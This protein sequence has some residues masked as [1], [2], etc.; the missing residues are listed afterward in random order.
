MELKEYFDSYYEL[1]V[2]NKEYI[3]ENDWTKIE[4]KEKR[5]IDYH[6]TTLAKEEE[7]K[8]HDSLVDFTV[9]RLAKLISNYK[10]SKREREYIKFLD[11][12]K[13]IIDIH[14]KRSIEYIKTFKYSEI[15]KASDRLTEVK[16]Q[17]KVSNET[18]KIVDKISGLNMS[19][20]DEEEVIEFHDGK[21]APLIMH[22][23]L[24]NLYPGIKKILDDKGIDF[25][26]PPKNTLHI[27]N[28]N[29]PEWNPRL[30]Y[31]DQDKETLQYY[32]DEWKKM[33]LGIEIDGV[34]IS[35]WMYYHMNFFVTKYPDQ[36]LN[37]LTGQYESID[38]IGTPPVRD[39]EW[40]VIMDNYE[41]AKKEGL[42]M[43]LA[44]TRRAAKTTMEASHLGH[45]VIDEKLEL[46]V[47]G[48]SSTDL[49]VLEKNFNICQ[50][51][52]HPAFRVYF[53]L[54]DSGKRIELGIK[55][56][57]SKTVLQ[58][59]LAIRNMDGGVK[60]KSEIFAGLTPDAVV[61]D[62][63]MK[64]PFKSQ[65]EGLKPAIDQPGGKRCVV[66]LAGC[67]CKGTKV[68]DAKGKVHNI[69]DI[70]LG[71]TILG[72][73]GVGASVENVSWVK[74]PAKKPCYRITFT[75]GTTLEC[76]NDHPILISE[77][78]NKNS[79]R[80]EKA[81]N[82][83]VGQKAYVINEIAPFGDTKE[84]DAYLLGVLI[85]DGYNG[86]RGSEIYTEGEGVF[87]ELSS[88]YNLKVMEEYTTSSGR[89]YRRSFIRDSKEITEK[90]GIIGL[91]SLYKKLPHNWSEYD[92]E[93]LSELI[94]GL[95]DSD[96]SV[97]FK[98]GHCRIRYNSICERIVK[99]LKLALMK[100]GIHSTIS[101]SNR[102]VSNIK[103]KDY[104]IKRQ[105]ELSISKAED[106]KLF[107]NNIK[108]REDYKQ[109]TQ[110]QLDNLKIKNSQ[111]KL[112]FITKTYKDKG[113][114]FEG[115]SDFSGIR[116]VT[117]KSVEF[118]GEQDVYNITA[119]TTHTYIANGII[120]HNTAGNEDLAKD[121][122]EF[123]SD[124][125][126]NGVLNMP[127]EKFNRM[128]P[129]EH[130]TWAERPFGTFIPA[131][132][133]AKDG[134]VKLDSNLAEFLGVNSKKL[135]RIPIKITDWGKAKEKIKQDRD[136]LKKKIESYT[137]EVLY[138]PVCPSEMLLSTKVNPFPVQEAI[139][140]R[141]YLKS[142]GG[143][144]KRGFLVQKNNGTIEFEMDET[145]PLADYPF[146]GGFI[147]APVVLYEDLPKERPADFL[148]VAGL[149]DYKQ[150]ESGT[151]SIGSFHI[152]KLDVGLDSMCGK[153][154]ASLATRPDPH[155]KF[156]H[157]MYLLQQAFNAKNFMENADM[158]YKD[159][160]E[161]RRVADRYLMTALDFEADLA[162]QSEGRRKYG[163]APTPKNKKILF[164][165]MVH[166]C[167]RI[168]QIYD[169]DGYEI[170][171]LGVQMI[172]DIGLLDE[173]IA[174]KEG[175]NVDRITSFMSCLAYEDYLV[176]NYMAYNPNRMI[177]KKREENRAIKKETGRNPFFARTKGKYF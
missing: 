108:L 84:T 88:K 54:E 177:E 148:Y 60:S 2:D 77:K 118:I 111:S 10:N 151:D 20:D 68:F 98:N 17:Q 51:N 28:P 152:Y 34:Y 168:F 70:K 149:D 47:A 15:E 90:A 41:M 6:S 14:T 113:E 5:K 119:D 62:E 172:D 86:P 37:R 53:T 21:V 150:D 134:M 65:V 38:V 94:A 3:E 161:R 72:Y 120:T 81:E 87:T 22:Y 170:D 42:M 92:K 176:A 107:F 163:W 100:F 144:G 71:D 130:I 105:Y 25:D 74:P 93:S 145:K 117:V 104:E 75:G 165:K 79:A 106:I 24:I 44:A 126:G 85:G 58:S 129:E 116:R 112:R 45:S 167:N 128:V 162:S 137:R 146:K 157:Q 13:K 55:T 135:A 67:V 49:Q 154:V 155:E 16:F 69:E 33:R 110:E 156:H 141:E 89:L 124:P 63:V 169:E 52:I 114:F 32:V 133:S 158:K 64:L 35:P 50:Q 173:I 138:Y 142:I 136:K 39:N 59:Y 30:H 66:I 78:T 102:G 132:M 26:T 4:I 127:W 19:L 109:I 153:I 164:Q 29:P 121:G 143:K 95:I 23:K 61:I 147:D 123:L 73:N 9:A 1:L 171:V 97:S 48:G 82:L 83:K 96:G 91:T 160:L 31:F 122:F 125:E 46:V 159:F 8:V 57:D 166:Y 139:A 174:Y 43:F 18:S 36:R 7:F 56:K 140:H 103:G 76:S 175:A 40:W 11:I 115:K 12:C 80:F 27:L 99:D 101:S 131:Q